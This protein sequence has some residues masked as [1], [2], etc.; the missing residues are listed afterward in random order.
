M[1]LVLA[2]VCTIAVRAALLLRRHA[3]P[4]CRRSGRFAE[5]VFWATAIVAGAR[6]AAM[7]FVAQRYKK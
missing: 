1:V 6:V 5:V 3:R 2:G 7:P 4:E